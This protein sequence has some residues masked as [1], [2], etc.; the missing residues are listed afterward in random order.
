MLLK[1][2]FLIMIGVY[3]V[4]FSIE[5]K[6]VLSLSSFTLGTFSVPLYWLFFLRQNKNVDSLDGYTEFRKK[7]KNAYLPLPESMKGLESMSADESVG[8][9]S[10]LFER[11]S[12][13]VEKMHT[14]FDLLREKDVEKIHAKL[15][16]IS[17]ISDLLVKVEMVEREQNKEMAKDG[18]I[19]CLQK[20]Y[21]A[22]YRTYTKWS[23]TLQNYRVF[24]WD[25]FFQKKL[26]IV[27]CLLNL[28]QDDKDEFDINNASEE[29]LRCRKRLFNILLCYSEDCKKNGRS[30]FNEG[31]GI[32]LFLKKIVKKKTE[33]LRETKINDTEKDNIKKMTL[34]DWV[35]YLQYQKLC[36]SSKKNYVN[37]YC[38][39]GVFVLDVG[40]GAFNSLLYSFQR[41]ELT[42]EYLLLWIGECGAINFLCSLLLL[43]LYKYQLIFSENGSRNLF[44]NMEEEADNEMKEEVE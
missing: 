28:K 25:E 40:W 19:S 23:T 31:K 4:C 12:L 15:R 24:S 34:T 3:Q 7:H 35:C 13:S 26:C 10:N 36:K 38:F 16:E 32:V 43:A 29:L 9:V 17:V 20:K 42:K 27:G 44:L 18:N 14:I 1:K 30:L 37:G 11:E 2:L 22:F 5:V 8:C 21:N 41:K 6:T 39:L 33:W